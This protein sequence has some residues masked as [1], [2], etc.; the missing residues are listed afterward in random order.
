MDCKQGTRLLMPV[1]INGD[2]YRV[3]MTVGAREHVECGLGTRSAWKVTPVVLD[4]HGKPDGRAYAIWFSD[5]AQHLPLAL[6]A[7]LPVGS[8][9][10]TLTR[11]T[12]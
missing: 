4:E 5:D 11:A 6:E 2:L 12:R 3:Q 10:L 7:E 1:I 9:R 8:F